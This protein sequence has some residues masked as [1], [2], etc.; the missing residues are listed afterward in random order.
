MAALAE[1]TVKDLVNQGPSTDVGRKEIGVKSQT[2]LYGALVE[3]IYAL[4]RQKYTRSDMSAVIEKL[5]E[6]ENQR[7]ETSILARIKKSL[8]F[9]CDSSHVKLARLKLRLQCEPDSGLEDT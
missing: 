3:Y 5:E 1:C 9:S 6:H 8:C 4:P 2:F 7:T